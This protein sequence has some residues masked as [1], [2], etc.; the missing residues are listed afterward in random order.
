[1]MLFQLGEDVQ[2]GYAFKAPGRAHY[3]VLTKKNTKKMELLTPESEPF[4]SS[5]ARLLSANARLRSANEPLMMPNERRI[6][7]NEAQFCQKEG[8][9]RPN[10][11]LRKLNEWLRK[12]NEGPFS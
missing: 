2:K 4:W 3:S 1:M 6:K 10:E 5:N 7:L 12:P 8:V 9:I 11:R